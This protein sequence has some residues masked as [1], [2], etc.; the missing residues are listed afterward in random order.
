M[1][2]NNKVVII[3]GGGTGIG[4][5]SAKRFLKKMQM[6]LLMDAEKMC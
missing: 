2:F 1:S 4:K 6:S 5:A 3:T